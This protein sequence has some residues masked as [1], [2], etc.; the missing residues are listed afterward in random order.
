MSACDECLRR[1][2]LVG[3]LSGHIEHLRSDRGHVRAVLALDDA[4]LI[5][6]LCP[7]V[8]A[9][10]LL[11]ERDAFDVDAERR[12]V[13]VAGV[14]TV[15]VHAANYPE[16]VRVLSDR[17]AV[18]YV[19]GQPLLVTEP[20]TRIAVVGS[21]RAGPDGRS[22]AWRLGRDLALAG[23]P[24]VSGMALGI[25]AAAPRGALDGGGPTVAV[26]G[27]GPDV[28]YPRSE[29]ALHER[30]R[31]HGAVVSELPP[32][33][34]VRRWTFP[35]RNRIIAALAGLTVVV[36]AAERSGSLITAEI[37]Q[38]L[39]REVGAMPG[40]AG[41][42]GA[43]GSNGLLRDG[44][45]VVRDAKDALDE[46]LG[47]GTR[48]M[49]RVGP[50]AA[51]LSPALRDL[52]EDVRRGRETVAALCASP[53]D[54]PRVTAGLGELEVLGHLRRTAEGRYEIAA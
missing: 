8:H 30:I 48:T 21:R 52:L 33:T 54:L 34:T 14:A 23:V 39:G 19:A 2:W 44:A 29:S 28:A 46:V 40:R 15:C 3:R 53:D 16:D 26:L 17:P 1:G 24:V 18:L 22:A 50:D 4:S 7:K 25:D 35:A 10:A 51:L 42:W 5:A 6:A 32:G 45:A 37:A 41:H 49:L 12:R 43:R 9:P 11:A 13:A 31:A 38:D 20:S 47:V 36:E 27:C